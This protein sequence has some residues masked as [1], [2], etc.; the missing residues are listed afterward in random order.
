MKYFTTSA[1]LLMILLTGC[2]S[3][4]EDFSLT[5]VME[6]MGNYRVSIEI[7]KDKSFQIHQQNIFFDNI[8]NEDRIH[9]SQGYLSDEEYLLLSELIGGSRLFRMKDSYGFGQEVNRS[10]LYGTHG[11]FIYHL[12]YTEGK[13]TKYIS[14]RDNPNDRYSDKFLQLLRFLSNCISTHSP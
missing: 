3:K 5:Y 11:D 10:N 8:A 7:G 13:K 9:T 2:H 4:P 14:I 12:I 1:L 6:S